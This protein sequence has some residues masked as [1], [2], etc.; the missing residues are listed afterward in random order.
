MLVITESAVSKPLRMRREEKE[1]SG[2][3]GGGDGKPVDYLQGEVKALD[4]IGLLI[5]KRS[6]SVTQ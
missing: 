1:K 2:G 6:N 3:G 4:S 5:A